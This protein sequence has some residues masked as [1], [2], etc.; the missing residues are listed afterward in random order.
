MEVSLVGAV[1]AGH[2]MPGDGDLFNLVGLYISQEITEWQC[3][4]PE[5]QNV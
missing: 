3:L 5:S 2:L 1:D 4:R